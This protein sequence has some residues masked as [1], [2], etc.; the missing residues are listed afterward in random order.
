MSQYDAA[1]T[2]SDPSLAPARLAGNYRD[3]LV[4]RFAR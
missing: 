1:K 2:H 3:E 4:L